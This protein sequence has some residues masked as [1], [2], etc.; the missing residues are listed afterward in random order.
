CLIALFHSSNRVEAGGLNAT[1]YSSA[2]FDVAAEEF[3]ASRTMADAGRWTKEMERI[4][5]EDL[6]YVT[7]YRPAV[8]EA[9]GSAVT[10]PVDAIMGGHG[11]LPAAWPESVRI[12][13]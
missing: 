4:I 7:L 6:P 2:D 9:Y 1:G 13:R 5:A 3:L 8:I 11:A 12:G 10:F